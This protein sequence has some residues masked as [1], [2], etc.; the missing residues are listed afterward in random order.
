MFRTTQ[1]EAEHTTF[2]AFA[3]ESLNSFRLQCG[4]LEVSRSNGSQKLFEG[5]QF[6]SSLLELAVPAVNKLKKQCQMFRKI[7]LSQMVPITMKLFVEVL[8]WC[9]LNFYAYLT[10]PGHLTI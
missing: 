10:K 7:G 6:L 5:L 8:S 3:T 2:I 1:Q 9:L 4:K